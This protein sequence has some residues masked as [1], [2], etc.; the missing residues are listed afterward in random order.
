MNDLEAQKRA[1]RINSMSK[2]KKTLLEYG[3]LTIATYV[4]VIGIYAFKF[5]NN[6]SFGGVTGFAI[7]L[8]EILPTTP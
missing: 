5:P 3:M 6:L 8:S 1:E 2:V 7:V 4:M